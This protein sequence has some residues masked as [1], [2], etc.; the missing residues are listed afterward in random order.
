MSLKLEIQLKV[1]FILKKGKN[2][3][4]KQKCPEILGFLA[5][6]QV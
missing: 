3:L 6:M 4:L 1:N 5:Q 2:L